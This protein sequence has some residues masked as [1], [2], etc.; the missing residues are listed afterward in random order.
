MFF[1]IIIFIIHILVQWYKASK[2]N[3][4]V[5]PIWY[6]NS[7]VGERSLAEMM[8]K[9]T[10]SAGIS[11]HLTNHCIRA[12]TVTVLGDDNIE[13]RRIRAVASQR[14]DSSID[15]YNSRPSLKQFNE[16]SNITSSF[17]T[18]NGGIPVG[19]PNASSPQAAPLPLREVNHQ[20]FNTQHFQQ[21]QQQP[22]GSFV[23]CTFNTTNNYNFTN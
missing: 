10:S 9:M 17:V 8:K 18:G 12:T 4:E 16:M 13:A 22:Q 14:S 5:D 21:F 23:G 20:Q 11:P 19:K 15:S 6:C 7:S 1:F 2:F 3:P